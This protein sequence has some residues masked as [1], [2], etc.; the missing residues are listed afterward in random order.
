MIPRILLSTSLGLYSGLM[1]GRTTTSPQSIWPFVAW[2]IASTAVGRLTF[3]LPNWN[4]VS[5]S[6]RKLYR[7]SA[8]LHSSQTEHSVSLML[9]GREFDLQTPMTDLWTKEV[10]MGPVDHHEDEGCCI[11]AYRVSWVLC[12]GNKWLLTGFWRLHLN[13]ST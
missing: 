7:Y 13:Q 11:Y 5:T 8:F 10:W 12:L 6:C 3:L 1:A 4:S 9:T 2:R